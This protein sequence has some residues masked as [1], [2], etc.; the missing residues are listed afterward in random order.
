MLVLTPPSQVVVQV[1]SCLVG[2][3]IQC[4]V[5]REG[6]ALPENPTVQEEE[7]MEGTTQK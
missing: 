6:G 1:L 3:E 2:N 7:N 5:L 4:S